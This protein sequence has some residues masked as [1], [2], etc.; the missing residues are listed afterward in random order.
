[1]PPDRGGIDLFHLKH[2]PAE[3]AGHPNPFL[4]AA[5]TQPSACNS[6]LLTLHKD[7]KGLHAQL[8]GSKSRR[9]LR[10]KFNKMKKSGAV[11]LRCV[12]DPEER[13]RAVEDILSWKSTQL[14]RSGDRDVFAR[15]S[16]GPRTGGRMRTTIEAHARSSESDRQ[17]RVFGLYLDGSMIAGLMAFVDRSAFSMFVT[18]IDPRTPAAYSAGTILLVKTMELAARSGIGSYDFLAGE[19]AYK[20]DWCNRHLHL[21]D[22]FAARTLP[23][24]IDSGV[25]RLRLATKKRIKANAAAMTLFRQFNRHY[26]SL[27]RLRARSGSC[28]AAKP[29]PDERR[30]A[31]TA[32]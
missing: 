10:E 31:R 8:R 25:S 20:F 17:M 12:R 29:H 15:P 28:M 27:S 7:W 21:M 14:E 32:G 6:H 18:A 22:T 13:Q 3:I 30:R 26:T 4:M 11:S 5:G 24:R 2:Q 19:E 16:R 1:M 23:G 9:R